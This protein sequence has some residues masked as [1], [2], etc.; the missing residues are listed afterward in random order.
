M[1]VDSEIAGAAFEREEGRVAP[2]LVR[3]RSRRAETRASGMN[4]VA[5]GRDDH[6]D[7]TVFENAKVGS[8]ADLIDDDLP[9]RVEHRSGDFET[10]AGSRCV[11]VDRLSPAD[12][13]QVA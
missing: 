2:A 10:G 9:S 8:A 11:A 4:E 12:A 13:V 3:R 1:K 6:L 5:A 7:R